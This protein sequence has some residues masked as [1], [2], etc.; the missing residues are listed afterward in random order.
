MYPENPNK[1]IVSDL[2]QHLTTLGV[3]LTIIVLGVA[4]YA[5][6]LSGEFISDDYNFIVD[7][8]A[9]RNIHNLSDIWYAFNSRF[10]VGLSFA[11]NFW[12]GKLDVFGYHCVNLVLHGINAFFV[13]KCVVLILETPV[14]K[15]DPRFS[16]P[17][18]LASFATLIFLC[19]PIQKH[20]VL[21]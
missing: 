11:V 10:L 12:L 5:H 7:N 13:Y 6:V 3:L 4:L 8:L 21:I 1:G 9:V 18:P 17:F 14:L 19:H 15:R 2:R 16:H 20:N